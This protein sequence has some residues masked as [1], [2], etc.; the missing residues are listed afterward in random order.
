MQ[1]LTLLLVKI[2][3]KGITSITGSGKTLT[4][5]ETKDIMKV[6]KPLENKG[7]L[8]KG[9][10]RKITSQEGGFLNFLKPLMTAGLLL[11]KNVLT[12]LAN[13]VLIPLGL[14]AAA[15]ATDAAI[16]KKFFGSSKT[17]LIISN[18]EMKDIKIVKSLEESGLLI[19]RKKNKKED[20]FQCYYEH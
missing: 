13:S 5:N 17:A 10:T 11:M 6:I 12:S 3:K 18:K 16:Q 9:T 20:F 7:I 14:S 2:I 19:K 1:D 4:N 15:S 8:L